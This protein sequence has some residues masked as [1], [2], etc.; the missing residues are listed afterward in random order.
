MVSMTQCCYLSHLQQWDQARDECRANQGKWPL[1]SDLVLE[2]WLYHRK[3][4]DMA[5]SL[6]CLGLSFLIRKMPQYL[7]MGL[8]EWVNKHGCKV[9]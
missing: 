6:T 4:C 2:S 9:L 3:C 7:Q 8:L 5:R 1:G